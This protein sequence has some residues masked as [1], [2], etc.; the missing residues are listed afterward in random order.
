VVL[1]GEPNKDNRASIERYGHARVLGEIPM[2][3]QLHRTALL[4]VF[5][6]HFERD[7]F[8]L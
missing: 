5:L 3:A 6:T 2:L 8:P 1:I 7:A 4:Q